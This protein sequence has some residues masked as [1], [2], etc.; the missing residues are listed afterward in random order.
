MWP[1]AIALADV[2]KVEVR[3]FSS[4]RTLLAVVAVPVTLAAV[5]AALCA[6]GNGCSP[7]G[8]GKGTIKIF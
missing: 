5:I 3:Q 6:V 2:T 4:T 1:V 8:N 7:F